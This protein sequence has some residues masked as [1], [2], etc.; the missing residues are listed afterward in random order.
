MNDDERMELIRRLSPH[1]WSREQSADV[2]KA[3]DADS[4]VQA[5]VADQ[6]RIEE[7]LT[8]QF[9][10]GLESTEAFLGKLQRR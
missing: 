3:F 7:A 8:L 1:Q 6:L 10:P 9:A 5:A 4:E 2:A